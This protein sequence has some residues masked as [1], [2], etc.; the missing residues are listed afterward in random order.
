MMK[1][2]ESYKLNF[3]APDV[4]LHC[5]YGTGVQTVQRLVYEKSAGLD[6]TPKLE[7]GDG[8]GTVNYRSLSACKQ[9]A[10]LQSAPVSVVELANVDHMGVLS[11]GKVMKYILDLL[12]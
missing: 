8:D 1:D 3:S 5:L 9:W 10:P 7:N 2:T 11:N 4:E 12:F 6:G